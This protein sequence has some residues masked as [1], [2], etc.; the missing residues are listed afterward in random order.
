MDRQKVSSAMIA[1]LAVFALSSCSEVS[2]R[3]DFAAAL[4][5]KT[6]AEVVKYAGK[7]V[8]IDRSDPNRVMYIYKSRTLDVPTRKTDPETDVILTPSSDGQLHVVEVV[9]K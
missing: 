5:N 6:E 8:Q 3:E 9:F 4:K 1:A 7:P 2:N